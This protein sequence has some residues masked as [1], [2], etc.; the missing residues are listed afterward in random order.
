MNKFLTILPKYCEQL[1]LTIEE[2]SERPFSRLFYGFQQQKKELV[3]SPGSILTW[4]NSSKGWHNCPGNKLQ[5]TCKQLWSVRHNVLSTHDACQLFQPHAYILSLV[6][7][8]CL[9]FF[10]SSDT[11]PSNTHSNLTRSSKKIA[12]ATYSTENSLRI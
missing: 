10:S 3:H 5:N 11:Q 8:Q 12:R 4:Y 2:S 1:Q 9:R 7:L 6:C